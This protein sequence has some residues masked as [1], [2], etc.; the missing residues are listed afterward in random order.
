[1]FSGLWSRGLSEFLPDVS[2]TTAVDIFEGDEAVGEVIFRAFRLRMIQLLDSQSYLCRPAV[3]IFPTPN[4]VTLSLA[5]NSLPS[6]PPEMATNMTNLQT[7]NL[8]YNSLTIVPIL[9]HSLFELRVL[10]MVANQ[11]TYLSNTSLLGVADHLEELDIRNFDLTILEKV[12]TG[13]I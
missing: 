10:T 9:T 8:N 5:S 11:I 6:M 7:L 2:S 3:P 1:M 4:L 12:L 13:I